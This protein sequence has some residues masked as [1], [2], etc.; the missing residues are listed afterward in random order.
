MTKCE[1]KIQKIGITVLSDSKVTTD[2]YMTNV[3]KIGTTNGP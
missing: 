2:I 3:I 1:N